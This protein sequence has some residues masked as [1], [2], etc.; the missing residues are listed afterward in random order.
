M[1]PSQSKLHIGWELSIQ[2]HTSIST[3]QVNPKRAIPAY[4]LL[5]NPQRFHLVQCLLQ[6]RLPTMISISDSMP[7][8]ARKSLPP[9]LIEA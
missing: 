3:P 7:Q 4:Q 5:K 9:Y 8:M 1:G 2:G 6:S